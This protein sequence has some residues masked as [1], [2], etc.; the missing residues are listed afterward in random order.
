MTGTLTLNNSTFLDLNTQDLFDITGG[1]TASQWIIGTC[2]VVGGIIGIAAGAGVC[3]AL[4]VEAGSVTGYAIC[5][6]IGI[7]TSGVS[8]KVASSII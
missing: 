7:V 5:G 2:T 6:V 1:W 8:N 3:G 4:G